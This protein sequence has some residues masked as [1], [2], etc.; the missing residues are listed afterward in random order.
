LATCKTLIDNSFGA[1]LLTEA[2]PKKLDTKNHMS[3]EAIVQAFENEFPEFDAIAAAR[4]YQRL[5]LRLADLEAAE[6]A[7]KDHRR[8][9]EEQEEDLHVA[10]AVEKARSALKHSELGKLSA[11]KRI[12]ALM[13][14]DELLD[15]RKK[16]KNTPQESKE[17]ENKEL[18]PQWEAFVSVLGILR[19]FGAVQGSSLTPLGGLVASLKSENE[20]LVALCVASEP[21][22]RLASSGST[23]EFAALVSTLAC[24][25]SDR[26]S[27]LLTEED[28]SFFDFA[29]SMQILGPSPRVADAV[30]EL[31]MEVAA[32]L[33]DSQ[34]ARGLDFNELPVRVDDRVAG[35]VESFAEGASWT[36][37]TASV[38][39]DDGDLVRLFRRT[40]DLLR[41]ISNL[42]DTVQL[43]EYIPA[44][45]AIKVAARNAANALDRSPVLDYIPLPTATAAEEEDAAADGI[46][47]NPLFDDDDDDDDDDFPTA[48]NDDIASEEEEEIINLIN[49][50]VNQ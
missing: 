5:S 25:V 47:N 1:Y 46:D 33:S 37:V 13:L 34:T 10:R 35:V 22:A 26:K 18:T 43:R 15:G 48:L 16:K 14:F 8:R 2:N 11:D 29:S 6:R 41:S 23:A 30:T 17:Q 45:S 7:L 36:E 40:T 9:N 38:A 3:T 32:P 20:L 42:D 12:R 21:F 44:I 31:L 50:Q 24:D 49:R 39:L 28:D 19:E 4:S 27:V